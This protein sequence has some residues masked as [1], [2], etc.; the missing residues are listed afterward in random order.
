MIAIQA[1]FAIFVQFFAYGLG[2]LKS[3]FAIKVLK[4]KPE[5]YYPNLFF[6]NAV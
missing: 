1:I 6:K 5:I 4:K 2:F 3:T